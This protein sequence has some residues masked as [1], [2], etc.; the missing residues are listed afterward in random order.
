VADTLQLLRHPRLRL[1]DKHPLP[2]KSAGGTVTGKIKVDLPMKKQLQAEQ[3]GIAASGR[4]ANLRLAGLVAGRDLDHGDIQFDVTQDGLK[5]S[6]PATVAKVAGAIDVEMDFRAGPPSQ[7]LQRAA[8][9]GRAT[10]ADMTASGIDP[11]GLI[12]AGDAGLSAVYV[13]QRDGTAEVQAKADLGSAGLSL[14]GWRKP[15]GPAAAASV[16]VTLKDDKLV[17]IDHIEASGPAMKVVGRTELVDGR[18]LL[19]RLERVVLGPTQAAGDIV[20]PV[21]PK[22]PIRVRLAGPSLDLS[23]QLASKPARPA[24]GEANWVADL[25]FDRVELGR[26]KVLD[27]V[28]AHAEDDGHHLRALQVTS[29]GPARVQASITPQGNG[30]RLSVRAANAGAL[31]EALDAGDNVTGGSL[32]LEAHYDDSIPSS[33]LSGTIDLSDFELHNAVALG[34][35]LQAITIYGIVDAL[36]G[37]GVQ[38]TRLNLPFRYDRQQLHIGEAHAYSSSLG[39]T[40]TGWID[41]ARKIMD[42][43][44]TI[45]PAY[46]INSA[47]GNI[48]MVGHLFSPEKGGGL[49]AINYAVTGSTADPGIAVNP[50]SALTPGFL[51][52]LFSIFS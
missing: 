28:V 20:F 3:V 25:R 33:P 13:S 51:R 30:R 37:D 34:K 49:I 45:V 10:A 46:A 24:E 39:I 18:P 47:L 2:I 44:G 11:G 16:L 40:A 4:L 31:F 38:F 5:A 12:T 32:A 9:T 26:G 36:R 35:L 48:P 52:R 6:G 1:L 15:P 27:G 22:D 14:A 29:T 41:F 23:T 21:R 50:L 7:V 19:L 8:M 42:V 17:A 43:R